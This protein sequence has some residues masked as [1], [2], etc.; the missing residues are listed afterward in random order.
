MGHIVLHWL[1][2]NQSLAW[3]GSAVLAIVGG[4]LA[5]YAK[6]LRKD[7]KVA[8]HCLELVSDLMDAADDNVIS[9][10]EVQKL[11]DDIAKIKEDAK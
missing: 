11:K 9:P 8:T 7:L 2:S 6:D 3:I 5:K 10:E 1:Q 4:G